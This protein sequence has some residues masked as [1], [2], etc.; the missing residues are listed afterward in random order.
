MVK[1]YKKDLDVSYTLGMTLTIELLKYKL[2]Y[3]TRIFIHSK[4][5]K[6]D[7]YLYIEEV[8]KKNKIPLI[9]ND[10]VFNILAQ[11]ENC[12]VIGEFNKFKAD[13]NKEK[14]HIV[15]VNPS[16][17]GNLGTIIRAMVGFNLKDLVIISPAV[18]IYDPKCVRASMGALFHL[19]FQ[20][21]ENF[22]DYTKEYDSRYYY[23]FM[24]QAS[25]N[26][27]EV[28]IKEPYSLIFGNEA[29]GLDLK[30]L[31]YGQ[32]VIIKHSENIDSLNLPIAVS[33]GIYEVTKEKFK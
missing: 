2:E 27:N 31:D 11:K 12:F 14:N 33:I 4:L 18:D 9:Q 16:N 3:V 19:N 1:R 32:S 25:R 5:I 13:V 17:A 10:K 24:L 28:E 26:L 21:F 23:P 30:Y 22:Q 6:N 8:C 29:T 15:L 7:A 20:Y